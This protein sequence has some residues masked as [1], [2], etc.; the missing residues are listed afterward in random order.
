MID[1]DERGDH[2]DPIPNYLLR[3]VMTVA[4][5]VGVAWA[6]WKGFHHG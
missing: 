3:T 1:P 6:L 2:I 4:V 5:L